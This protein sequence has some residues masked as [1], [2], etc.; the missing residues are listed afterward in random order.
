[1]AH[2]YKLLLEQKNIFTSTRFVWYSNMA[3]VA[4]VV[5]RNQHGCWDAMRK[6]STR[7]IGK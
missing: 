5:L 3:V 6:H 7:G 2:N 1:M 4:A